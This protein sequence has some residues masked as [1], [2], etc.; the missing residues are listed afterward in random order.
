MVT[1]W[2]KRAMAELTKAC[3]YIYQNSPKN[4]AKIRNEIIDKTIELFN[5]PYTLVT[6]NN[7]PRTKSGKIKHAASPP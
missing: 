3:A 1:V 4:A 5:H 6:E 2:S 7:L